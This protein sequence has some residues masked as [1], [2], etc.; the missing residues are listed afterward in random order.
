MK[1]IK[2]D[3]HTLLAEVG[4]DLYFKH[5]LI[6]AIEFV[7]AEECLFTPCSIT[8]D[9]RCFSTSPTYSLHGLR[10][11]SP[12]RTSG[13]EYS[14]PSD[15]NKPSYQSRGD[16]LEVHPEDL[17]NITGA[18]FVLISGRLTQR[19]RFRAH[20]WPETLVAPKLVYFD[21]CQ[22][23]INRGFLHSLHRSGTLYY[24]APN[25]SGDSSTKTISSFSVP[26][27]RENLQCGAQD[28]V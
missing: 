4:Q 14:S 17:Q 10:R 25:E 9:T 24:V 22:L 28:A 12:S 23:G 16:N 11:A 15:P 6:R 1:A 26:Y 19:H 13:K 2:T 3:I 21:S 7:L 5:G 8:K 20:S 27:T 18:D